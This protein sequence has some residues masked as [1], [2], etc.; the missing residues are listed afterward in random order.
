MDKETLSNYGWIVICVLV[1]AV[2]IALAT[3]F[4]YFISGAVQSTTK[5]LFDVNHTALESTGLI[6]IDDQEFDVPNTA[7]VAPDDWDGTADISWYDANKD[8]FVIDTAEELAGFAQLVTTGNVFTGKTV[9]LGNSLNLANH[10]WTPIGNGAANTFAGTFDGQG[11]SISNMV[12]SCNYYRGVG[13]FRSL[14]DGAVIKN[15]TFVNANVNN[16]EATSANHFYGVVAGHSKNLTL[17]NVDVKDSTVTCKYSGAALVGCMEGATVIK[18]CDIENVTLNTTNAI[19]VAVF[20][21]IGN[22]VS[23]HTVDIQN[24]TI[25][26]VTSFVDG[27]VNELKEVRYYSEF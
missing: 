2:M 16:G 5:G 1:L 26:N 12:M 10:A 19:R 13:F 14:G 6:A 25:T 17:E 18:D 8:E 23:G 20:G 22:S 21:I 24:C 11:H 7:P 4:G 9:K 3:P 15:L 27:A